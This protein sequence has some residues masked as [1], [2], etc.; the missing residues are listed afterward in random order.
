MQIDQKNQKEEQQQKEISLSL[1]EIIVKKTETFMDQNAIEEKG[2]FILSVENGELFVS[3][4]EN[5]KPKRFSFCKNKVV[6]SYFFLSPEEE[7]TPSFVGNELSCCL[8]NA[9][10]DEVKNLISSEWDNIIEEFIDDKN[11][12][13]ISLLVN[14]KGDWLLTN[15]DI[16]MKR[17]STTN[18][19]GDNYLVLCSFRLEIS[20]KNMFIK[21][22]N[23][24]ITCL[25][26]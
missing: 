8:F 14:S 7:A 10:K 2:W 13:I 26:N 23:S 21:N 11:K 18:I 22:Y 5:E 19:S 4:Q 12:Q 25:F 17:F 20:E 9:I 6:I 24:A 3:L 16:I 1:P 15:G